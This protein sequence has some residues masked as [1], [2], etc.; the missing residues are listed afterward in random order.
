[1]ICPPDHD[2][3]NAHVAIPLKNVSVSFSWNN[4]KLIRVMT[5]QVFTKIHC[6]WASTAYWTIKDQYC[7]GNKKGMSLSGLLHFLLLH[8]NH[9]A[10]SFIFLLLHSVTANGFKISVCLRSPTSLNNLPVTS[11]TNWLIGPYKNLSRL[12]S[13]HTYRE[14]SKSPATRLGPL[15]GDHVVI[16]FWRWLW[17]WCDIYW[18]NFAL[19]SFILW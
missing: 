11:T 7:F 5:T 8:N 2:Y 4:V 13:Y 15:R 18:V 17:C 10:E 3:W 1:M 14:V 19:S 16:D 12:L 9:Q 6:Q